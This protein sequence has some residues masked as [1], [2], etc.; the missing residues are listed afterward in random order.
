MSKK[1]RTILKAATQIP[2]D[3]LI[4]MISASFLLLVGLLLLKCG[5]TYH[6]FRNRLKQKF[7]P[8]VFG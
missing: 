5:T 2:E 6:R 1:N 3:V 7:L 4:P 8:A